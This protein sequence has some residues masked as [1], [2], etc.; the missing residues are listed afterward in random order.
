[1]RMLGQPAADSNEE[2]KV[3]ELASKSNEDNASDINNPEGS[4]EPAGSGND[5]MADKPEDG[6]GSE[7]GLKDVRGEQDSQDSGKKRVFTDDG[8]SSD[9]AIGSKEA[10]SGSV[11]GL[12]ATP[13][14]LVITV[15]DKV[16]FIDAIVNNDRFE[17]NY[18][19]FG[20]KVSVT[21]RSLTSEEGQAL[22]SW[23]IRE[24]SK[25]PSDQLAGRYRKYL[26]AA[27]VSKFNGMEM[28]PL[29]EPLFATLDSDGV[30]EK[31]PAWIDR[32]LFWDKQQSGIIQYLI[33]CLKDFDLLYSTL[34]SKAEDENFWNP[35]TP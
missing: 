31:Q 11:I 24:G 19:A 35:D 14:N 10:S 25:N 23:A 9:T 6:G 30:T 4:G 15:S 18:S 27:Q 34:C 26:I 33:E 29:E 28:P 12:G 2:A 5:A 16:N 8:L 7:G 17:K 20:G 3:A 32:C 21:V 22:A 13:K 1:M